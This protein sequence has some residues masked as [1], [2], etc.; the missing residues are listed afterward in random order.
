MRM[1]GPAVALAIVVLAWPAAAQTNTSDPDPGSASAAPQQLEGA[2]EK[3]PQGST[4]SAE[5]G[6]MVPPEDGKDGDRDT[7]RPDAGDTP[8]SDNPTGPHN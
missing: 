6:P 8:G 7:Y 3:A 1:I 4:A 5:P 2:T